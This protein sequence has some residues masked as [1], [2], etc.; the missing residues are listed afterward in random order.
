MQVFLLVSTL[1]DFVYF[2]FWQDELTPS[3]SHFFITKSKSCVLYTLV[4]TSE[5]ALC[6]KSNNGSRFKKLVSLISCLIAVI[7]QRRVCLDSDIWR[8]AGFGQAKKLPKQKTPKP[9]FCRAIMGVVGRVCHMKPQV[10]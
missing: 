8:I 4:N 1:K 5:Q 10:A 3:I 2:T 7:R 9:A 6:R